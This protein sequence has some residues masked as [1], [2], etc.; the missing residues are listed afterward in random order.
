MNK[1]RS[2]HFLTWVAKQWFQT[3]EKYAHSAEKVTL[4][5]KMRNSTCSVSPVLGTAKQR[6]W[7]LPALTLPDGTEAIVGIGS[8]RLS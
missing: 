6:F 7:G 3:M 8:I 5:G 4:M 1:A 2:A